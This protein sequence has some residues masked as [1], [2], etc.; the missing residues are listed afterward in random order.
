MQRFQRKTFRHVFK[1][2]SSEEPWEK[3]R[4]YE[5][6]DGV[7][8]ILGDTPEP[9]MRFARDDNGISTG[10]DRL[11]GIGNAVTPYQAYPIFE[12]IAELERKGD[13]YE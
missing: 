3:V 8:G 13:N 11:R 12:V 5:E 6:I 4:T 9:Y 7:F 1:A 10:M 2:T